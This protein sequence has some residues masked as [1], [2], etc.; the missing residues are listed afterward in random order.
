[1]E[2]IFVSLMSVAVVIVATVSMTMS[3]FTSTVAVTDS[4]KKIEERSQIFLQ[5]SIHAS[6]PA[7]YNGG[8]IELLVANDGQTDLARFEKWDII[9][10]YQTG[11][12]VYLSHAN[13]SVPD[14]NMWTV[15]GIY[16]STN[17]SIPEAFDF[18]I[19]NS[20]ETVKMFLNVQ[21]EVG[22]GESARVTVSTDSGIKSRCIV[23]RN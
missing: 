4:W 10:E 9:V 20:W 6:P 19:L 23:T 2:S 1:M 16:L 7:S 21:P 15:E 17:T 12:S 8:R 11:E 3:L 18:G 13:S 14:A 5:T 22:A